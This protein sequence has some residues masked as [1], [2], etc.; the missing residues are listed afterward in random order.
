MCENRKRRYIHNLHDV[1]NSH[2]RFQLNRIKTYNLKEENSFNTAITVKYGQGLRKWYE[3]VKLNKQYRHA[4]DY[5]YS[6][7]EN[8]NVKVF[9]TEDNNPAGLTPII[10]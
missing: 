7:Q 2:T 5:I 1:L 10:T 8:G 4:K 3:K 9:A 6:V